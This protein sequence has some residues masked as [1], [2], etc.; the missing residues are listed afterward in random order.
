MK[1]RAVKLPAKALDTIEVAEAILDMG[2]P[3]LAA[4]RACCAMFY[5]RVFIV[6][7]TVHP[8]HR[9]CNKRSAAQRCEGDLP[10]RGASRREALP[11]RGGRLLTCPPTPLRFGDDVAGG[12]RVVGKTALLAVTECTRKC[13][14]ANVCIKRGRN[15][16][17]TD[18]RW[19]HT[20]KN[21]PRQKNSIQNFAKV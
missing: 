3:E 7:S 6:F 15:S 20:D 19:A 11:S 12:A 17:H 2:K 1:E 21:L 13:T 8:S 16:T 10:D 14:A 5:R 9:R 4:G 18:K